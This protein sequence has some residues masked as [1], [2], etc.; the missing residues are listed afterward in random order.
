MKERGKEGKEDKRK[1]I[2]HEGIGEQRENYI[3]TLNIQ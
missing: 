2:K 1:K 3:S